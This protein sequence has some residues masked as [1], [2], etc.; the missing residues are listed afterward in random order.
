ME[1]TR[2]C[3]ICK[4]VKPH[5][6]F[7]KNK[8]IKYGITYICYACKK[9][10][11]LKLFEKIQCSVCSKYIAKI[12]LKKHLEVPIHK[13]LQEYKSIVDHSNITKIKIC[14]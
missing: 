2:K 3:S 12:S 11:N 7:S 1:L 10:D 13:K 4:I 5:S 8:N 14:C 6:E 9:I